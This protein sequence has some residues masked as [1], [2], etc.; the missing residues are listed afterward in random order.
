MDRRL[1]EQSLTSNPFV[2]GRGKQKK[3]ENSRERE[4]RILDKILDEKT[5]DR[6]IRPSPKD[7]YEPG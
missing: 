2:Y 7:E 3:R 5:Y 1:W 6:R 4:K